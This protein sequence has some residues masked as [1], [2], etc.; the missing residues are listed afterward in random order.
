[1]PTHCLFNLSV[2]LMAMLLLVFAVIQSS[3]VEKQRFKKKKNLVKCTKCLGVL[4]PPPNSGYWHTEFFSGHDKHSLQSALRLGGDC[5]PHRNAHQ[6]RKPAA[7]VA[8]RQSVRVLEGVHIFSYTKKFIC[9]RFSYY[10]HAFSLPAS[11]TWILKAF[12][13][14]KNGW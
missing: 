1:M 12:T 13:K 14:L 8:W 4:K 6:P 11:H 7:Q 10:P 3:S 2:K 9:T 5:P